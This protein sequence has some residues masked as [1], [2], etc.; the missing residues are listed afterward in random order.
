MHA[1]TGLIQTDGELPRSQLCVQ[2]T[3]FDD[4][5]VAVT[6]PIVDENLCN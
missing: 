1:T 4:H 5:H 6:A 3:R 2:T